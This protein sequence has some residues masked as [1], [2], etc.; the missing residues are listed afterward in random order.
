M[1]EQSKYQ[2]A[3]TT[4]VYGQNIQKMDSSKNTPGPGGAPGSKVTPP[5]YPATPPSEPWI[6]N[7]DSKNFDSLS[8]KD[9]LALISSPPG[10]EILSDFRAEKSAESY[11]LFVNLSKQSENFKETLTIRPSPT[12][13][14]TELAAISSELSVV[15]YKT[16]YKSK[17]SEECSYNTLQEPELD[18]R[19]R[20]NFYD[21]LEEDV[22]SQED[23]ANDPLL[24]TQAGTGFVASTQIPRYV[25]LSWQ[26]VDK[27][28]PIALDPSAMAQE[29]KELKKNLYFTSAHKFFGE[30]VVDRLKKYLN[31]S[32]KDQNLTEFSEPTKVFSF[33]NNKKIFK[34]TFLVTVISK[35]ID[36]TSNIEVISDQSN[37]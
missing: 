17:Y 32:P 22:P 2:T 3:G 12:F 34:N 28:E 30:S 27:S 19:L 9:R 8:E 6:I 35:I 16:S 11:S 25:D 24:Q 10:T 7:L 15:D 36:A 23:T 29:N 20:Y 1:A 5:N 26:F 21:R 14:R 4:T 13:S 31:L 37:K 18:A 33:I